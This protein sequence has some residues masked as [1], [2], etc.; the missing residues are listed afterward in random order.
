MPSSRMRA[1]SL[2]IGKIS[3]STIVLRSIGLPRHAK[4]LRGRSDQA[5]D[6]R[7]GTRRARAAFI[8][9]EALAGLL[10][11]APRLAQLIGDLR[12]RALRLAHAPADV[13][14]GEVAHGERPHR[15]AK[16]RQCTVDILRQRA[17][18]QQAF[19][20]DRA[21]AQHPV[22][23]KAVADA[24]HDRHFLDRARDRQ[25]GRQHI[26]R[27]VGPAHDLQKPHHIR[28]AEEMQAEHGCRPAGGCARSR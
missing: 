4:A 9:V 2:I 1:P 8:N 15:K 11:E 14:A 5:F 10:P 19:G 17:F 28:R 18:Q 16:L 25:S 12:A 21:D 13:E 27:G 6:L 24:D 23:D 3:R 20:L 22:A 26:R 7:I